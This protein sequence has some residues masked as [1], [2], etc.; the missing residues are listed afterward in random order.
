MWPAYTH[1]R[2]FGCRAMEYLYRGLRTVTLENELIRVTVLADKGS[3]IIEFLHKPSDTDFMWRSPL[4][5]RNPA[6]FVPTAP[7]PEGAFLDYYPGGWQECLPSGGNPASYAGTSFGPHGELCLI[8]WEYTLTEDEPE[9]VTLRLRV[10]TYRTPLFVEKW[11]TLTSGRPV[12]QIRERLV[13]EGHEPV[14]LM[15]GHH[16]AFGPPFLDD[17]C[18]VD[19]PGALV[20]ATD[21]LPTHR[22]RPGSGYVWPYVPARD[23][24][25][26]DIS[27]I[28]PPETRSHD[29][30][31][32]TELAAGWYAVTNTRRAVGFGMAW[33]AE[34]FGALWF[35]QVYGGA[36]GSPW[37]G[38]TYNIAIEPWT[39]P[40]T[41]IE[42]AIAQGSS[43]H[44]GPGEALEAEL[45][46]VAYAGLRRVT[47]ISPSGEVTGDVERRA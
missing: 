42:E 8:P 18:V 19:L 29:T 17:S 41:T 10:R 43:R 44:L 26:L 31:F 28:A 16:P 37:F 47:G 13:N 21:A 4:G 7:R 22:Y 38:R 12:L 23:G 24:E 25:L 35:W 45:C 6:T 36:F 3:D 11:L 32:L 30:L 5:V 2:N 14:E 40:H 27:K 39:T 46:A 15:W 33:P 20:R 9:R 34:L 1:E